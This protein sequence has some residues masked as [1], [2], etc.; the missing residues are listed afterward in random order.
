M[1]PS[2]FPSTGTPV[3]GGL[4]W[5]QTLSLFQSVVAQRNIIG[6]DITEFAPIAGFHSYQFSAAQ[7]VY[8]MMGIVERETLR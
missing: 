7:L 5:Y 6:M 4:G 8:K 3:P 2:I 1:D